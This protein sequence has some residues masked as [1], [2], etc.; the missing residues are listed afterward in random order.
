MDLTATADEEA[1]RHDLPA[2]LR[3]KPGTVRS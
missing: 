3:D 1:L 2:W